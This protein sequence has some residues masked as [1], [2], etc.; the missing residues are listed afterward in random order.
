MPILTAIRR[1]RDLVELVL[2]APVVDGQVAVRSIAAVAARL[3]RDDLVVGA[4]VRRWT[5]GHWTQI[6]KRKKFFT[7]NS[8][9]R[10][11]GAELSGREPVSPPG[12]DEEVDHDEGLWPPLADV[13]DR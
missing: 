7:P 8:D 12:C 9:R 10:K 2:R 11:G 3:A 4:S 13:C 6:K 5:R 1:G